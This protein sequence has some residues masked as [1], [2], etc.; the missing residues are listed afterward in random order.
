MN[1]ITPALLALAALA[2]PAAAQS[3]RPEALPT[4]EASAGAETQAALDEVVVTARKKSE[5]LQQV[6]VSVVSL[7]AEDQRKLGI[8]SITNLGAAVP[9]LQ[10]GDLAITSR[11]SL[12]GV[13]SGDNNSFEQ[14]VGVYVDGIFRGRMNQ[15]HIGLFDL[16]RVEVLK[17]P[18]VALYGNSSIGGAISAVTRKPSFDFGGDLRVGYETEYQTQRISGGVDLPLNDTLAFRVAG[19]WRDQDRG[20]SPNDASG[21]SEPRIDN[22]AFR[23]GALWLPNDVLLV[24]LRHER[25]S[26]S[27]DGHIFDVFRH[28]DGQGN[29]WPGSTFTGVNDGRLNI[30]NGAPFKYQDA[31]LRTDMEE[32]MLELQYAGDSFALT[33]ISGLSQYDYQQSADVDISPATLINVFQDE[34]YRQ[35]S[36]E[37]RINGQASARVDYLAGLYYQRDDF[38]NDYWSDFNLPQLV[39]PAFGI[40]NELAAQLL[41]PF[42]RHI[43]IDQHTEQTALFGHLDIALSERLNGALGMRFQH[44]RKRAD[45]AVRGASIDHVDGA[46]RLIDL[47]WLNPQLAPLLL[48]NPAYL[49]NPTG[50]VLVLDDGTRINPVLAPNNLVGYDIVSLGAGVPHEF[51]NLSRR[52]KHPMLQASLAWQHTPD[53]M[54]YAGWS[55]GAKAGGFDFL[56]EGGD[57]DAVEYGDENASVFELGFKRDWRNLRLNMAAFH[58][59]YDGLQVSVFDGGIGFTV[60]NAASSISRGIDGELLWQMSER[61]RAMAQWSWVDFRYDRFPDA[62]CSTTERLNGLGPLCDW[63]GRRT[64]F[65]PVFEGAVGIEHQQAVGGWE[66]QHGLRVTYKGSHANASDLEEQTRQAAYTLVDY[67]L[68]V[69]P[70]A[71]DWS[72]A[73]FARNLTDK[74]YNVFTSVIPLA[75]GGAFAHVLAPGRE[76]ALELR[77]RF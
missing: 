63:S 58:G 61:W 43:L 31:F 34:A 40:P 32:T 3:V 69:Q 76:L 72:L 1:P 49:A 9:G 36:Q 33:S 62:N 2:L 5:L 7:D 56:Y 26:Y 71:A 20:I 39:A 70:E 14:A 65:V 25:G 57:A 24:G 35:F 73:V 51:N 48:A 37:L 18:Q 55:N 15:Q 66:L 44:T 27:R 74:R 41:D 50:Y 45:Q 21:D 10:Q 67:R 68:E 12:R 28:V 11:L 13:N 46:G 22:E 38:R 53:L 77:W 64:P 23:L 16:E 42:T 4:A 19:T 6:P 75:P 29:P 8:E 30:G 60:G 52:E 54:V 17:G 59:R 47:R